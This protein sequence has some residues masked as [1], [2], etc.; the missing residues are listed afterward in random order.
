M[1]KIIV[2]SGTSLLLVVILYLSLFRY[3][4]PS[5]QLNR[6][7][8]I[9][10]TSWNID[11]NLSSIETDYFFSPTRVKYFPLKPDHQFVVFYKDKKEF[12]SNN[13]EMP[14]L[15]ANYIIN[16]WNL[17]YSKNLSIEKHL[18]DLNIA[19]NFLKNRAIIQKNTA[20]WKVHLTFRRYDLPEEWP[21]A[22]QQGRILAGIARYYQLTGDTTF[23]ELGKK[24]VNFCEV[25]VSDGGILS[26]A[27]AGGYIYE[28]YPTTP[29]NSVLNGHIFCL[30][31]LFDFYRVTKYE[32]AKELF[33]KGVEYLVTDLDKYDTGYW[34]YYDLKTKFVTDYTYHVNVHIPQLRVL[35]Q[36]TG[37]EIFAAYADKWKS[38]LKQPYYTLFKFEVLYDAF[39]R[40]L[41]YKSW[42]TRGVE[43][44]LTT[45]EEI[46]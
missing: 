38:Y 13:N 45:E 33:D 40:R 26:N 19:A 21:G 22:Y 8:K 46:D 14:W 35:Y 37:N 39:L 27:E 36:I 18:A 44:R 7:L 20:T 12:P 43:R 5:I 10:L 17:T 32:K 31:G 15:A 9:D 24:A 28:E 16:L 29:P 41:T 30:F 34:S 4:E 6:D 3:I 11:R 1:K 42:L 2:Y 25:Q 23:L